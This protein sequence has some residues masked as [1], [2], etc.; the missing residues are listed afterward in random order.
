MSRF[1]QCHAYDVPHGQR[2]AVLDILGAHHFTGTADDDPD[3]MARLN[4]GQHY[5]C[6]GGMIGLLAENLR[7][8]APGGA[9]M[10]WAESTDGELGSVEAYV[11]GLGEFSADCDENGMT[12]L[13]PDY[14]AA[15]VRRAA[16]GR[17]ACPVSEVLAELDRESGKPWYD[18]RDAA[19]SRVRGQE[20][21][22]RVLV[23]DTC[24]EALTGVAATCADGCAQGLG[25]AGLC[26]VGAESPAC[27]WCG[28][29]G[30][31][32]ESALGEARAVLPAAARQD[33]AW[34]LT[35]PDGR[36]DGPYQSGA[37]AWRAWHSGDLTTGNPVPGA[38]GA[39]ARKPRARRAPGTATAPAP[40][41]GRGV[42]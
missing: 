24:E 22:G 32:H 30:R 5:T 17:D 33:R 21:S 37:E 39:A 1:I 26:Q 14:A 12:V 20:A 27:Q 16:A 2:Q 8:H 13:Y 25:H 42:R 18:H 7:E 36:T 40:P 41:P 29:V 15:A 35:W 11:P 19:A 38:P 23:C 34:A 3:A 31:L 6:P 28:A 4:L 9:F 10:A